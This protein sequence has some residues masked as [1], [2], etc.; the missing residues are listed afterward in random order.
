MHGEQGKRKEH[1][2]RRTWKKK[3]GEQRRREE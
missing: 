2:P 3:P 1:A